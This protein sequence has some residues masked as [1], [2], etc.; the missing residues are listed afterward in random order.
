MND[1]NKFPL[2]SIISVNYAQAEITSAMIRSIESI[3][4]PHYEIII[5]DNVSDEDPS[6]I[7]DRHPQVQLIR[8]D[9]NRG[10]AGANNLGV[11]VA[12]GEYLLF[13]NNDTEVDPG[14][15]EPLVAAFKDNESLGAVSPKII[16]HNTAIIQYAGASKLN[17]Y[18]GRAFSINYQE[19]DKGQVDVVKPTY[20]MVGT[21]MMLPKKVI[22]K[23]GLMPEIYFMYYEEVEWSEKIWK[24]GY[25]IQFVGTS[26]VFHKDSISIGADSPLKTYYVN[27]NRILFLRRNS[28]FFQLLI[29]FLYMNVFA[30]PKSIGMFIIRGKFTHLRFYLKSLF[31]HLGHLRVG[32]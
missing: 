4:Y 27:R 29:S 1:L 15:L 21:A 31:W 32:D 11:A 26:S 19:E 17:P 7:V 2:V 20:I 9:E 24:A 8:S 3:S 28:H 25:T 10:F 12:K 13:L 22:E 6:L 30:I 5:V 18:T 23:V 14:F 16:Y